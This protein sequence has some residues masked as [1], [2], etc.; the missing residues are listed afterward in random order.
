[1]I[2]CAAVQ[3]NG[4]MPVDKGL[5]SVGNTTAQIPL[6]RGDLPMKRHYYAFWNTDDSGR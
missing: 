3:N 5:G 4:F 2:C 6:C 1:M